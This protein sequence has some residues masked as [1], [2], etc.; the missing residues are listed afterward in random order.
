MVV[1]P[2]VAPAEIDDLF[3]LTYAVR[4]HYSCLGC[5]QSLHHKMKL[6]SGNGAI[7][8]IGIWSRILSST[9]TVRMI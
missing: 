4:C 5:W 9:Y 3:R 6:S 2:G 7:S 1:A 8:Q